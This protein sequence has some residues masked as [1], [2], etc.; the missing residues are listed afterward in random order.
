PSTGHRMAHYRRRAVSCVRRLARRCT[1]AFVLTAA[2]AGLVGCTGDDADSADGT[3]PE[4]PPA[5]IDPIP[6]TVA[7]PPANLD[8]LSVA[9]LGASD[10][11]VPDTWAIRDLDPA[12]LDPVTEVEADPIQGLVTCPPGAFR[13]RGAWLQRTFSA[14]E[15]PREDGVLSVDIIVEIEDE[16]TA[17]AGR[18]AL[19]GCAAVGPDTGVQATELQVAPTDEAGAEVGPAVAATEIVVTS[20]PSADVPYPSATTALS[21]H[22]GGRTVTLVLGGL[23]LGVPFS[24][25]ARDLVGRLLGRFN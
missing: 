25:S 24:D 17:T 23:D 1:H 9:L 3:V 15:D 12:V 13:G 14:P 2:L 20:A 10:V 21:A 4:A 5:T 6:A 8:Q 22:R 7:A 18:A 11:G 19:A 16:P